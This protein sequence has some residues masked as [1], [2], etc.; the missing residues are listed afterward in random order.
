VNEK[1][2]LSN[3]KL[4]NSIKFMFAK[5]GD[6]KKQQKIKAVIKFPQI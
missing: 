2:V 1:L 6:E 4:I 3:I 5:M